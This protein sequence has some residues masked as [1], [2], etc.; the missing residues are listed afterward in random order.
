MDDNRTKAITV[1]ARE[2]GMDN[3]RTITGTVLGWEERMDDN[4]IQRE[5]AICRFLNNIA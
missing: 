4:S 1:L 3:N 2:E 5:V